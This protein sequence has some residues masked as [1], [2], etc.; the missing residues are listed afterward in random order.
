MRVGRQSLSG[1]TKKTVAE[2]REAALRTKKLRAGD[3][4][5]RR[6]ELRGSSRSSRARTTL[7]NTRISRDRRTHPPGSRRTPTNPTS[8]IHGKSNLPNFCGRKW[9]SIRFLR[10][11][12]WGSRAQT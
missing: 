7:A 4:I 1:E 2:S 10:E 9:K 3:E 6:K 8:R 12:S 11:K 5:L